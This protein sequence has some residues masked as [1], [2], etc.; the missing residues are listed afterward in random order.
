MT[1]PPPI[2][3]GYEPS[4]P[5]PNQAPGPSPAATEPRRWLVPALA[6]VAILA[7]A[8]AVFFALG[9]MDKL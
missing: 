6:A 2:V 8:A 3:P 7:V 1:S 9:G 5:P 4:A